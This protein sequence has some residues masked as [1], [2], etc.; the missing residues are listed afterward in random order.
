MTSNPTILEST[1]TEGVSICIGKPS[2]EKNTS[3]SSMLGSQ[4]RS[5]GNKVKYDPAHTEQRCSSTST[6]E[7][8]AGRFAFSGQGGKGQIQRIPEAFLTNLNLGNPKASQT[9]LHLGNRCL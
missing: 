8:D 2:Q 3:K 1:R 7:T 4:E 5:Q 9:N 6:R